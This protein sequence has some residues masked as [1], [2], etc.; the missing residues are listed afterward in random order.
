MRRAPS[1][2]AAGIGTCPARF[3]RG[4]ALV[5]SL[6]VVATVLLAN[7]GYLLQLRSSDPM[8][9]FSGLGSPSR[10]VV[11]GTFTIDPNYG[12][13]SQALGHLAA[14]SWL[15]G[16]VPLWNVYEGLGQPLGGEMQSAAFFLPFVLLQALPNGIFLMHVV[17]ELV[18]G[19]GTLLFLRSHRL[20]WTASTTAACLFAVNGAF[21]VMANAP[22]N[23]I[24][25]L[26]LACWGVELIGHDVERGRRPHGGI[27]VT[28]LAVAFM[29]FAG[30]PETALL[31][32]LFVAG[33][34]V[35]RCV[36]LRGHRRQFAGWTLCGGMLGVVLAAPAVVAF[37][38]FLQFGFSAYHSGAANAF[39]Y[40]HSQVTSLALPYGVGPMG[41]AIS[42]GQAGYLTLT[43]VLAG[44]VGL[45]GRR[46]RGVR[47]F[48][49]LSVALLVLNMFGVPPVHQVFNATPGVRNILVAK[50]GLV[51]IEF[52][53][54]VC[55][56]YGI[57][58]LRNARV[59]RRAV[60]VGGVLV[61]VYCI[62]ALGY[63]GHRGL[64]VHP[65]W[66]LV[67]TAGTVLVCAALGALLEG[68]RSRPDRAGVLAAL[69]AT[70]VVGFG[71]GTYAVPQLSASPPHSLDLGPVHYLQRNLGTW[72]FY[73][74]GPIEADYGSYWHLAQFNA[75][76]LPVA[77][78]YATLVSSQVRP[79]Y[80]GRLGPAARNQYGAYRLGVDNPGIAIQRSMLAAYGNRQPTF[81]NATVRYVMTR[82]G[83][84]DAALGRRYGLV[85][86]YQ[87]ASVEIWR[88]SR[89][90]PYYT[91][92]HRA[93]CRIR[94]QS[95]TAVTL[96]CRTAATL[97][98]RQL[99]ST[100]WSAVLNGT[101]QRVV[102]TRSRLYQRIEV[103]AG[104][105]R[106]TF[107]YLPQHFRPAVGL[108]LV[109]AALMLLD[110]CAFVVRSRRHTVRT[111]PAPT[112]GAGP[113]SQPTTVAT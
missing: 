85:R 89:A 39:T 1:D 62:G 91:T 26:P 100:G 13:T 52:A 8:L 74:L 40:R 113:R 102:D 57:D 25:F 51:L 22:V 31:E 49:G 46:R 11:R 106:V 44:V 45:L 18:A 37:V 36:E 69:A 3:L 81:R 42:H 108:S 101:R 104:T 50:Y 38:D 75:D 103:P 21:S 53:V 66:T 35:V 5:S 109:L 70:V 7:A 16:H 97:Y 4:P 93:G 72:R 90:V 30:F 29:L 23:P 112:V 76:D 82:R 47:V 63:A 15:H 94:E 54:A 68:G 88:D 59:R 98:R 43:A 2:A 86:V 10:G 32:G 27:W 19:F 67:V 110:G 20:S 96:E 87:D 60:V 99:S 80:F 65:R 56:A 95:L 78:K 55:A 79:T 107:D 111:L 92:T 17:L 33:W 12:W 28:V 34:A 71:A 83:V 64:L 105:S 48:L 41:N 14:D 58:D 9:Y 6:C 61:G 24:A 77:S 73:S 84:A